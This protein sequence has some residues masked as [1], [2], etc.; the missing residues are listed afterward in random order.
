MNLLEN[1]E[2][3]V[4]IT[5]KKLFVI[6]TSI[7]IGALLIS[8]I[9]GLFGKNVY[10]GFA[11]AKYVQESRA[12]D[13]ITLV[14]GVPLLGAAL[15]GLLKDRAWAYPLYL[16]VLA[17]ELYVYLIYTLGA[18]YNPLFPFYMLITGLCIYSMIGILGNLNKSSFQEMINPSLPRRWTAIFFLMLVI[19]F[20][21]VWM[22]QVMV[23][24]QT[25]IADSGH[26]IFV[27]DLTVVL[28]AFAIAAV[29][30]LH[31]TELGD[32]LAGML[33]IKFDSLCIS[34]ALGQWFRAMNQIS[35]E[36]G[37]L[38][39]FIP[40][41]LISMVLTGFYFKNINHEKQEI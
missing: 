34:I 26:F 37:L 13:L 8:A 6:M 3:A 36:S 10:E 32:V 7:I 40:F 31:K 17:Y 35:V 14:L 25:G 21:F 33:L 16:G 20:A 29:H 38:F 4:K 23:S 12:Q 24:I 39:I 22:S 19:I 9:F 11:P 2:T 30:L 15:F 5:W 41:G 28:P 18:I 27:I 1:N